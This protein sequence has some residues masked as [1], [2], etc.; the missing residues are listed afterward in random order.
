MMFSQYK[1][2]DW[3]EILIT[4]NSGVCKHI[5]LHSSILVDPRLL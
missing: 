1:R 5:E 3:S 2:S 4:E